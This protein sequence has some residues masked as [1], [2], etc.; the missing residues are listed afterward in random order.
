MYMPVGAL[1]QTLFTKSVSQCT[2]TM[3]VYRVTLFA[4]QLTP[5]KGQEICACAESLFFPV[6]TLIQCLVYIIH[7]ERN[8]GSVGLRI[9]CS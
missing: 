5:H 2:S 1:A 4:L 9:L 8:G 6:Q 3:S 7:G